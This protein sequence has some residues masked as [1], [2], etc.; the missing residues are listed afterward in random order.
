MPSAVGY[1][2]KHSFTN[3]SPM[4]IERPA[5]GPQ[6]VGITVLF[7]GVCHSDLHQARNDWKNTVYPC[8]PGHEIIGRVTAV[9]DQVT[10]FSLGDSVGVGCMI[11]SCGTCVA[12][13]EHLEQYCEGP[14]GPTMT[15]NG[16]FKPDGS[17]TF[18]GYSTHLVVPERFVLRIPHGLD[19]EAAAPL[20]CAGV[21]T[22]SP[23]RHWQV[24]PGQ[25]VGIVGLG[26]LGHVAVKLATAMGAA[27]T[28]FSTSAEKEADARR[29]GATGFVLSTDKNALQALAL[30]FDLILST[31]PD[32]HDINP[33]IPTLKRDA[34][35]VVVGALGPFAKPTDNSQVAFHRRSVAGSLIGGIAETQEVLDFCA[36]HGILP[37]VEIIPMSGINDAFKRMERGEVRYRQVID[38]AGTLSPNDAGA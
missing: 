17:N 32:A 28:V 2:T 9:G 13:R 19:L 23:L 27:V 31:V 7:C 22:Y 12:C 37:E 1:A 25:R 16:P 20:L 5:P 6:D 33:Y 10:K 3:L 26:G 24:R 4:R 21:T 18:G 34:T 29:F 35:L 30:T 11:D 15:Y 14:R 38:V 8:M 36:T